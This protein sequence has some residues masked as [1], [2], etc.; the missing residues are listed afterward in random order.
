MTSEN[1]GMD[2]GPSSIRTRRDIPKAKVVFSLKT[3]QRK[4]ECREGMSRHGRRSSFR[5]ECKGSNR[6]WRAFRCI[7]RC[8]LQGGIST[9]SNV[10][11]NSI[12]SKRPF[13]PASRFCDALRRALEASSRDRE[14]YRLQRSM[15]CY[16][17]SSGVHRCTFATLGNCNQFGKPRCESPILVGLHHH[18][19]WVRRSRCETQGR[20]GLAVPPQRSSRW[21]LE[22]IGQVWLSSYSLRV[23]W[24]WLVRSSLTLVAR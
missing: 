23:V 8:C 1:R 6:S 4:V 10:V 11:Y 16:R 12:Q 19:T 9:A 5:F 2:P 13:Y 7:G 15:H 17:A 14:R 18:A 3:Q 22:T 24:V 21:H 20:A